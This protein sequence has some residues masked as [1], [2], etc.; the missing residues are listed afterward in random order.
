MVL[1][2]KRTPLLSN[3]ERLE[4][5]ELIRLLKQI[6]SKRDELQLDALNRRS[7]DAK[8]KATGQDEE[9]LYAKK[10]KTSSLVLMFMKDK[11]TQAGI[12]NK[13]LSFNVAAKKK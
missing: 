8:C 11:L 6:S 5:D 3:A 4:K 10:V 2:L 7:K 1:T 13:S 9:E 12:S